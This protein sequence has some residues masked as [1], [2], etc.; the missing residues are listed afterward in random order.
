MAK[1]ARDGSLALTLPNGSDGRSRQQTR[2]R[3]QRAVAQLE[4]ELRLLRSRSNRCR[5]ASCGTTYIR[6]HTA[7]S[8]ARRL[9]WSFQRTIH[10]GGAATKVGLIRVLFTSNGYE[11]GG[12]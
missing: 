5:S 9:I 6:R 3:D 2:L 11:K 1:L 10:P 4:A 12:E 7:N 8:A